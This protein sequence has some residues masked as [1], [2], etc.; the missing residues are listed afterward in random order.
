[1][2]EQQ[3][4]HNDDASI[5]S[6]SNRF[7]QAVG[8]VSTRPKDAVDQLTSLQGE[9]AGRSLFSSNETL[10]DI[11]T[12]SLPFL[13]LEHHLAKALVEIPTG[14]GAAQ[15]RLDNLQRAA[16]CW[17]VFLE[18]LD[19]L[20]QLSREEQDQYRDL[21]EL[22]SRENVDNDDVEDKMPHMPPPISRDIKIAR[23]RAQQAAA[24]EAKKLKGLQER[25]SRLGIKAEDEMDGHD[26]ESLA[27]AVAL[28]DTTQ[29]CK[30]QALEEWSA[31]LQELPLVSRMVKSQ[32][33]QQ[34]QDSRY[35]NHF[36]PHSRAGESPR[37]MGPPPPTS[38]K[39][40]E[41]THITQ[42][43]VTGQLRMQRQEIKSNVFRPGWNQPTMTLEELAEK[44][45]QQALE[46]EARQKDAEAARKNAPRRYDQLARDGMEDNADLVDASAALD[47]QWDDFKDENP[48]GS[49]N[50]RGDVGDRNF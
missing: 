11:A 14:F 26:D 6:L 21:L 36:G 45:V 3:P 10:D 47:R 39:P 25:R 38:S 32:A 27:R 29:I 43:P 8:L 31:V 19:Q 20:E 37:N 42:N 49:G 35:G 12:S 33:Q 23:F 9:I 5:L 28:T 2:S 34:A 7:D 4:S 18:R 44:E 1:M 30:A 15:E 22:S 50:K 41:V 13:G 40:L 17:Q 16:D 46:R 24:Q 48:R